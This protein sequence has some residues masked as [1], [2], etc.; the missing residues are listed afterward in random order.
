MTPA[1][2][3]PLFFTL[4]RL[5]RHDVPEVL[6]VTAA[7]RTTWTGRTARG[8]KVSIVKARCRGQF[9]RRADAQR[10]ERLARAFLAEHA[11]EIRAA[12]ATLRQRRRARDTQI[13]LMIE[14]LA[15]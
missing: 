1:S 9:A 7:G 6:A 3:P 13:A 14:R 15:P 4:A 2:A 10:A 11:R 8:L 12:E 5:K